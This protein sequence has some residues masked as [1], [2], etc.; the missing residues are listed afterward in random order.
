MA[1]NNLAI[2]G[3]IG[4]T[5]GRF[6]LV[7]AGHLVKGSVYNC[8][9]KDYSNTIDAIKAFLEVKGNPKVTSACLALACPITGDTVKLTN[10]HWEFSRQAMQDALGLEHVM[11]A[12]DFTALAM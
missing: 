10:C 9:T 4:G 8:P 2:V 6:A 12:N 1:H 7:E 11:F 5:N 3:D